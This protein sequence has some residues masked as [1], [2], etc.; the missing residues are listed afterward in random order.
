MNYRAGY[1]LIFLFAAISMSCKKPYNPPVTNSPNSYLVVE[2][3]I[4][5]GADSTT[6]KL[7]KTVNL[8]SSVTTNPMLG[9]I[10]TIESNQ[11]NS[12]PLTEAG[13]GL[14]KTPGLNL[15][16]TGQYRLRIKTA[17]NKEYLSDF[18][19]VKITQPIDSIGYTIKNGALQLYNS[20]HDPSNNSRYYRWDY[21]E[22]WEFHSTY[23]SSYYVTDDTILLR[24]QSLQIYYCYR[25]DTSSDIVLG[26]S[27][28]LKQDVITQNPLTSI[29]EG[30]EKLGIKYSI[31]LRQYALTGDAYS[32]WTLL[33]KN[34]EQ[35]G[36]IFDAQPS[37]ITG[38]IHSTTNPAEP[39]IGYISIT[40]VQTK[41]IFISFND[42]PL[43]FYVRPDPACTQDSLLYFNPK[44]KLNDVEGVLI[45]AS[46]GSIY[47][48][49][50]IV[51]G[52]TIVG[53]L[54]SSPACVDCTLR[55]ST[56]PPA[57]WK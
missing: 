41:R 24:P 4:N 42:L 30:S 10:L 11:G 47:P 29:T 45:K 2:G 18:A 25:S 8:S 26:S 1:F 37:E 31:L 52:T 21:T 5:S 51:Q 6:I 44:T 33:K 57:F 28:G 43:D 55:G 20:T 32:F 3:V 53:Y 9:A 23:N 35:L 14:Y 34:T 19:A 22:T 36:S 56:T 50:A 54:A 48:T 12:Y 7:S 46:P 17:D 40:N 27:A 16:T 13:N 49:S 15:N 39:V 38:N